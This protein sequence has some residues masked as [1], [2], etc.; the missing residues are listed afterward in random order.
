LGISLNFIDGCD[1]AKPDS[2]V[3]CFADQSIKVKIHPGASF[4]CRVGNTIDALF[5]YKGFLDIFYDLIVK[6]KITYQ[7]GE[8]A[9]AICMFRLY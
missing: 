8:G 7:T 5:V 1:F 4:F 3:R 9:I 2:T 6:E